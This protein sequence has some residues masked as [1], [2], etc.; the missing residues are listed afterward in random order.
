MD[1]VTAV[2]CGASVAFVAGVAYAQGV[3]RDLDRA[4]PLS[5]YFSQPTRVVMRVAYL[6]LGI[7]LACTAL[8]IRPER[9]GAMVAGVGL[10][11]AVLL[12]VAAACLLPVALTTGASF[13][14]DARSERSRM[15]HRIFSS[16]A[17]AAAVLAMLAYS[18]LGLPGSDRGERALRLYAILL[19][20]FAAMA[21]ALLLRVPPGTRPYGVCQKILVGLIVLWIGLAALA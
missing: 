6:C 18:L 9:E 21:F 3:R 1:W 4:A 13:E 14:A 16:V 19:A 5:A 11:S 17:L 15:L 2:A 12:L 8:H 20:I 10:A 7:A